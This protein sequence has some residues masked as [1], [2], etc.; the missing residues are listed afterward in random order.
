MPVLSGQKDQRFSKTRFNDTIKQT[1]CKDRNNLFPEVQAMEQQTDQEQLPGK[2][3]PKKKKR[4][5]LKVLLI[6]LAAIVLAFIGAYAYWTVRG[7]RLEMPYGLKAGMTPEEA[8]GILEENGFTKQYE[9]PSIREITYFP[10]AEFGVQEQ[11]ITLSARESAIALEYFF[12]DGET[13]TVKISDGSGG[14]TNTEEGVFNSD[15]PSRAFRSVLEQLTEKYGAPQEHTVNG[16]RLYE[17]SGIHMNF[18]FF[19]VSV[20]YFRDSGFSVRYSNSK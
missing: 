20:G 10:K 2:K 14:Y 8:H 15:N 3:T 19:S 17:W 12:K 7:S 18:E 11:F 6:I 1:K 5:L 9:S 4:K 13:Q 16:N